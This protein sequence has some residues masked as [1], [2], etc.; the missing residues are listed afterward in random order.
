[1]N[2]E[3]TKWQTARAVFASPESMNY[4]LKF[5]FC[6]AFYGRSCPHVDG[7]AERWR[8]VWGQLVTDRWY[9]RAERRA[10]KGK[11]LTDLE[12]TAIDLNRYLD[13]AG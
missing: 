2:D 11:P 12:A 10:A 5:L 4:A 1:V 3:L 8:D 6:R 7:I 9:A 13:G